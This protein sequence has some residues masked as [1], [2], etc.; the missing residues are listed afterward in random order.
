M[1]HVFIVNK[2]TVNKNT[3]KICQKI[4][5]VC[6]KLY[7]DFCIEIINEENTTEEALEKY[8][9]TE[10]IIV[11]V[12]GDGTVNRI[13]NCIIGTKNKL[14]IIPIGTGNDF[15]KALLKQSNNLYNKVDIGKINEKYFIN[16][17]CFGIDADV[18][19][20]LNIIKSKL[21]PARQKYNASLLYTFFKYKN[22]E[23]QIEYNGIKTSG[24]YS[25]IAIC[26]GNY[27]GGGYN[28]APNSRFDDGMFDIYF[29]ENLKKIQ[30]P[31]LILN[32][33]KGKHENSK[34]IKK[35]QEQAITIR[36][37]KNIVCNIDGE[38]IEDKLF[39][40]SLIKG[41]ITIYNN[42]ELLEK[43]LKNDK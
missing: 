30:F 41:A 25:T 8:K 5:D 21:I 12:G 15:Y 40:I 3:N 28:I 9:T 37:N 35:V 20:N 36:S 11:A 19:N 38:E 31:H 23:L 1:K 27:Y 10:N 16:V 17:A 33:K 2:F 6:N 13:L 26:N 34:Y 22:K 7:I 29:A 42:Q 43:L 14:G 32:V 18:A 39:N 24:L 4:Q